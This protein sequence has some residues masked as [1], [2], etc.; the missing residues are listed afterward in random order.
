MYIKK[1][2]WGKD[3]RDTDSAKDKAYSFF[4]S[5]RFQTGLTIFLFVL[6]LLALL[7]IIFPNITAY[8]FCGRSAAPVPAK[9][10]E[11]PEPENEFVVIDGIR[12]PEVQSGNRIDE[13]TDRAVQTVAIRFIRAQYENDIETLLRLSTDALAKEIAAAPEDYLFSGNVAFRSITNTAEQNGKYLVFV[14]FT[15]KNEP[16]QADVQE[17]FEIVRVDGEYLV[18]FVGLS[19]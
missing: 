19:A 18:S 4:R 12:I 17:D 8:I 14:R 15:D 7:L 9:E 10:T 1:I 16:G 11:M 6:L 13:E 2:I 5:N 3:M